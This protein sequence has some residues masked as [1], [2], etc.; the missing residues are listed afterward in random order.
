MNTITR[1]E[2]EKDFKREIILNAAKLVFE[3]NGFTKSKIDEIAKESGFAKG[4][5]YNYFKSKKEIMEQIIIEMFMMQNKD[6]FKIMKKNIPIEEK[7]R[8]T[9]KLHYNIASNPSRTK[10]LKYFISIEEFIT[11]MLESFV[12]MKKLEEQSIEI[13][14]L[15]IQEFEKKQNL[16][17]YPNINPNSLARLFMCYGRGIMTHIWSNTLLSTDENRKD[18]EQE[19]RE[20]LDEHINFLLYNLQNTNSI[21]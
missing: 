18:L 3:K 6:L 14:A 19:N 17:C 16:K 4:S 8:K 12:T 7:I 15:F 11:L 13:I 1:K 20:L 21:N 5:I 2:K 10:I 9:I